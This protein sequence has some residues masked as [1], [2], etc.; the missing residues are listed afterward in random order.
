[1]NL[2]NADI[3]E[4]NSDKWNQQN[5]AELIEKHLW[6]MEIKNNSWICRRCG[7]DLYNFHKFYKRIEESHKNFDML[8]K[9]EHEMPFLEEQDF[10]DTD[11]VRLGEKL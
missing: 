8:C 5:L 2:E 7:D 10:N 1:G 9:T 6:P 4:I 3:I 11:S